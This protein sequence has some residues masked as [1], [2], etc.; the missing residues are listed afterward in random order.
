MIPMVWSMKRK[1]YPLG[2]TVK[3]K[4]RLC[5]GGYWS[6]ESIN[7][8]DTYSPVVSLSTVRLIIVFAILNDWHMESIDFVLAFPQ[9]P[10]KTN[11]YMKPPKVL[12]GFSIPE[13][14]FVF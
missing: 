4:A 13:L 10:I 5:A 11:I 9:A 6:I 3:W 12:S 14:P 7:Y 8:W 2:D 1:R